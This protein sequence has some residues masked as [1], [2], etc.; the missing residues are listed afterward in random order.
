MNK[1][2]INYI[3]DILMAI[4]FAISAV[5]GIP[6]Y[7]LPGGVY[8]GGQTIFLGVEKQVW[9]TIHTYAS[10]A[11]VVIVL[12]H[13]ILHWKWIVYMTKSFFKKNST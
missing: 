5:T 1:P 7:M 3:I 10:F 12:V 6:L 13:L 11:L 4:F 2:K 9:G 8:R